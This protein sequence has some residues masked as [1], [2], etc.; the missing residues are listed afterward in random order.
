MDITKA[1]PDILYRY[2]EDF[3]HIVVYKNGI[4]ISDKYEG[5]P[6]I[7]KEQVIQLLNEIGVSV[8][9]IWKIIRDYKDTKD[10]LEQ[11]AEKGLITLEIEEITEGIV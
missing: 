9:H 11:L 5:F 10:L 4:L 6:R 1:V 7:S 3:E 8:V 2:E